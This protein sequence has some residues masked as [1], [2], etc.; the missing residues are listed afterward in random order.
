MYDPYLSSRNTSSFTPFDSERGNR[1]ATSTL[2]FYNNGRGVNQVE[3]GKERKNG[4]GFRISGISDAVIAILLLLPASICI[5]ALYCLYKLTITDGGGFLYRGIRLGRNKK[6][7][8]ML[9]IRTL[10]VDAE[11]QLGVSMYDGSGKLELWYGGFLRK[12]RLDELPQLINV[13]K[14]EMSLVGPRPVRPNMYI[15]ILSKIPGYDRRFRVLPGITGYSQFLTPHTTAKWIRNRIDG[16]AL[17]RSNSEIQKPLFILWTIYNCSSAGIRELT[18]QSAEYWRLFVHGAGIKDKRKLK[19]ERPDNIVSSF[20]SSAIEDETRISRCIVY[21]INPDAMRIIT[22]V[23]LDESAQVH[24]YLKACKKK[25][26]RTKISRIRCKA[27]VRFK[28]DCSKKMGIGTNTFA[29]S[30]ITRHYVV[31]YDARS[32]FHRYLVDKYILKTSM[33]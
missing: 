17:E 15:Q 25:G 33:A 23:P 32:E 8:T 18:W 29:D 1:I 13:I 4:I 16:I 6:P 31:F 20:I 22:D 12:T 10:V 19:R 26:T 5:G 30:A 24:L 11:R 9:K 21:D 27:M 28:R 14:G 7:F 3:K 2:F